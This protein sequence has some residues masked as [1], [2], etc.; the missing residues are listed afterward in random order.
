MEIPKLRK[1]QTVTFATPL[2]F[3]DTRGR[4][5]ETEFTVLHAWDL[6]FL[7]KKRQ[8]MV[9][10]L[11]VNFRLYE[12]EITEPDSIPAIPSP[13]PMM[14][15]AQGQARR[16]PAPLPPAPSVEEPNQKQAPAQL[17]LF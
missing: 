3:I 11:P 14:S 10:I 12:Y 6:R 4:Y 2:E 15:E 16:G 9:R 5:K 8:V 17:S 7:A 1:G 13:P